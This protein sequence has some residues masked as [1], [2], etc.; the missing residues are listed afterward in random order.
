V[1]ALCDRLDLA[2]LNGQHNKPGKSR[3][4]SESKKK[5]LKKSLQLSNLMWY[6]NKVAAEKHGSEK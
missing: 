4:A 5:D 2:P 3:L 6:I 1:L